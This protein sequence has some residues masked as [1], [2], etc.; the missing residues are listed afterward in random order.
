MGST[1]TVLVLY[2]YMKGETKE[3]TS[4]MSKKANVI[5]ANVN[6][7]CNVT[8]CAFAPGAREVREGKEDMSPTSSMSLRWY[9]HSHGALV[10]T[11]EAFSFLVIRT[12]KCTNKTYTV[13]C[14]V[15]ICSKVAALVSLHNKRKDIEPEPS[16]FSESIP[17]RRRVC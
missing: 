17:R 15:V 7:T 14:W 13:G 11:K 1:G 16:F 4:P 9:H 12:R 10:K 8:V 5:M 6:I 2:C 3:S